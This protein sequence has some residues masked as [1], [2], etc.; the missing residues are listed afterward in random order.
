MTKFWTRTAIIAAAGYALAACA[1]ANYP[2]VQGQTPREPMVPAKPNYPIVQSAPAGSA[3]AQAAPAAAPSGASVESQAL[4]PVA[5]AAPPPSPVASQPLSP[6]MVSTPPAP[7]TTTRTVP[8]AAGKVVDALGKPS[9]YVVEP[10]DTLYAI[11]RKLGT[12]VDKLAD[13]NGLGAPYRLQPGQT[14]KGPA[15]KTKAYVVEPG[16]TL[17]AIG[18]RFSVSPQ[19]IADANGVAVSRPIEIGQKLVLPDGYRDTGPTTRTVTVTTTPPPPSAITYPRPAPTSVATTPPPSSA[20]TAVIQSQTLPPPPPPPPPSSALKPYTPSPGVVVPPKPAPAPTQAAPATPALTPEDAAVAA[21]GKDKFTWPVNGE[22][23]SSFGPKSGG[24]RN[25]GL[26]IRATENTVV[27]AAAGGEVVYAGDQVPG[28]GNL[29]L[30]KHED[31]WVTAYAHLSRVDVK[32]RD[33]V[34]QGQQLGLVGSTGG[35][36]EPQLHF[37]VRYAPSPTDKAKPIDPALVLP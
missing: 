31:G 21:A 28:F 19:Q 30:V 7:V 18:R 11:S 23:I 35:V 34:V 15:P 3:P 12:S 1:T 27:R 32:M 37:E 10:G 8:T 6:A 24:Q 25:D 22:V 13:D 26:N 9:T 14:L 17:Y 2:T 29:V 20:T 4:P 33:F 36:D 16:D 5:Q